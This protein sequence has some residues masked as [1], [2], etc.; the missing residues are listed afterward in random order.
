MEKSQCSFKQLPFSNLFSTYIYDYPKLSH[1][2]SANPFDDQEVEAR[3]QR[4]P[5]G[6]NRDKFV[7]ALSEYHNELG[8]SQDQVDQL[9]KFSN[10]EALAVVT[11][12]Q[13]GIYG[14][15]LFTIYKTITTI[16]LAEKW[17]EKLNRPVVPVFWL[18][19][20]DHDFEEIAS[21]GIP[22]DNGKI[23]IA[24]NESGNG[25]PVSEELISEAFTELNQKIREINPETDFS[26]SMWDELIE[27]Y[28]SGSTHAQAFSKLICKWLARYGLLIVGSNHKKIKELVVDTFK[29]SV[30]KASEIHSSLERQSSDL[31]KD[32][33]RQ[34]VVGSTNLFHLGE[35][36]RVKLDREEDV[37]KVGNVT[38]SSAS[39]IEEIEK[40][41]ESFSPNV[42]LR[43][44]VQD[45]LLP[46]IGYVAGP[47]ELAY[48]AQ[49]KSYYEQFQME[50]PVIFPRLSATLLESGIDR[51]M[52][53]LPF[54][55]CTYNQRIE[56][57]EARYIE[58]NSSDNLNQVF[59]EWVQK[60]GEISSEPIE[61]IQSID[62][63]LK[64]TAGKVV[65]GFEN[66]LNK[67]KGRVF[68]SIKQQEETQ[69]KRIARIK[70]QLFPDGLQERAISPVYFMN[71]Y[72]LDVWDR[73]IEDF[74]KDSLDL[75]SHHI[76]K[77]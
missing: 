49:M 68:R 66:E 33:H 61:L 23:S 47:G 1:F 16:L 7:A 22:G 34:V 17:E 26:S 69:L 39:L 55:L 77:L 19:D 28:K 6:T 38:F 2:F 54:E 15:P 53:K 9:Q 46:T 29:T 5:S 48:Y 37:W 45:V 44:I 36:G 30:S 71:K 25:L 65:S 18:A 72:G 76:I 64:G 75:Q 41:P 57:L 32:F 12:Q 59:K 20:E 42:F 3:I 58:L 70:T 74:Q 52:E 51:I 35:S 27:C 50:M 60:V 24:L 56:D 31:E 21:L 11:G 40:N 67:L 63:T 4:T 62:A 43:P 8:I 73:I 13:L 10:P 14:G